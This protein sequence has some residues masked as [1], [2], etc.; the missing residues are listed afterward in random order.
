VEGRQLA[1]FAVSRDTNF[2]YS[3]LVLPQAKRGAIIAVWDFCRAVD[4]AVDAPTVDGGA[5]ALGVSAL[6]ARLVSWRQELDCCFSESEPRTEEGRHLKPH[7]SRFGLPRQPFEDLIDGVEMDIGGRRYETFD[8][9]Y[10]YCLRVA[11]AVG[12]ICIEIFEYRSEDTRNYA[13]ALG[14]A[15][16]LTNIIRDVSTDFASGRVYLPLEDLKRFGCTD[17][18]LGCGMSPQVHALLEFECQRAHGFYRRARRALP[19]EDATNLVAAQIMGAIYLEILERIQQRDY[20][21]FSEVVRVP[22]PRR[23]VI[24]A[25]VWAC[26]IFRRAF[27]LTTARAEH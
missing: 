27:G 23:V 21:V 6:K 17:R 15:L 1:A 2:Y 16:Q 25:K 24:A 18:D 13:I 3:F 26:T 19:P 20:D 11:S 10:Q 14:V 12:L 9:L 22:R 4:D 5:V 8:D 7:V